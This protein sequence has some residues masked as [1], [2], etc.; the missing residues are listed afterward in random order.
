MPDGDLT[1]TLIESDQPVGVFV[2]HEATVLSNQ[3]TSPCCADHLEDQLF[4]AST[5]GKVLVVAGS[6]GMCGAAALAS[7]AAYRSGAGLVYIACPASIAPILT[8]R[9]TGRAPLS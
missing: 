5:W 9:R 1:G 6:P 2:G 4:P 3:A 7:Q 8:I